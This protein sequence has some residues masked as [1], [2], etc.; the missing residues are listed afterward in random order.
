M[1]FDELAKCAGFSPGTESA[2]ADILAEFQHRGFFLAYALECPME[3]HCEPQHA[4]N[5][6]GP[7]VIK[8]IQSSYKPKQVAPLGQAMQELIPLLELSGFGDRLILFDGGPFVDPF[9]G[10]PQN[11]AEFDTA[12]GDRLC[13]A[14]AFLR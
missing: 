10:D 12:L 4:L 2:E 5:Q 11:Q 13:R 8:R 1:Y 7:T 6:M 9:L 3:E 14:L